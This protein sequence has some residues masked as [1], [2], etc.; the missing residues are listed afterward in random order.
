MRLS[1]FLL[2]A[3]LLCW[4]VVASAEGQA[5]ASAGSVVFSLGE[6]HLIR[7]GGE[8]PLTKGMAL[9]AGDK[10]Q[11]GTD[12]HLQLRMVDD[13]FISIKPNS[14]FVIN[15]Y[16]YDVAHPEQSKVHF[17]LETGQVRS[18]TGKAGEADKQRFRLNTPIAAIGIRGTDFTTTAESG[19]TRV[20]V[21][22]GAIVMSPFSDACQPQGLGACQTANARLLTA[23]M[24]N[25]QLELYANELVPRLAPVPVTPSDKSKRA[26]DADSSLGEAKTTLAADKVQVAAA[27][28]V[29]VHSAAPTAPAAPATPSLLPSPTVLPPAPA[30]IVW[31]R[32]AQWVSPQAKESS[33]EA[34][35][36][37]QREA[38]FGN[39]VFSLFRPNGFWALPSR[40]TGTFT[41]NYAAGEA[42]VLDANQ[43]HAAVI[44][45]PSLS[46][47]FNKRTF[48]TAL[49]VNA[50]QYG[51]HDL[52]AS[53]AVQGNGFLRG[54][55]G[56]TQVL[57]AL[58]PS[59]QEAGY[60]FSHNLSGAASI[61][62]VTRW[63]H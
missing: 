46:I 44:S 40:D 30:Q 18:V 17:T 36:T 24:K 37:A 21:N 8:R 61:Q 63:V 58:T 12:G 15:D 7:A 47:D 39:Q 25:V 43:L 20:S 60:V 3:I 49:T 45:N 48:A 10:L 9:Q 50:G 11:T 53:G 56:A 31:G 5:T 57:G 35:Y 54:N 42:V 62:G 2:L 33:V 52:S 27:E 14:R 29:P 13:G 26:P 22:R 41:F 28:A 59:L 6:T 34:V 23:S 19:V 55:D 51:T 16:L 38:T 32:W 1:K 4:K